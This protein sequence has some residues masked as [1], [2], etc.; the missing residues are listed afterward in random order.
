MTVP[1]NFKPRCFRPLETVSDSSELTLPASLQPSLTRPSQRP[2][3]RLRTILSPET[4]GFLYFPFSFPAWRQTRSVPSKKYRFQFVEVRFPVEPLVQG[5]YLSECL[6]ADGWAFAS[7]SAHDQT[8]VGRAA[9]GNHERMRI[10][11]IVRPLLALTCPEY[12]HHLFSGN[13]LC[14]KLH[15]IL[16][17]HILTATWSRGRASIFW[18]SA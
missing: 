17:K 15:S 1:T 13:F 9:Q 4:G 12:N 11:N 14:E 3:S 18:S 8:Q 7:I 6:V 16:S 10:C 2:P 5:T